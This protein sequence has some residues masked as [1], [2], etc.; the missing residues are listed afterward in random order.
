MFILDNILLYPKFYCYYCRTLKYIA[1]FE[2]SAQIKLGL[3]S[4][5]VSLHFR[6]CVVDNCQEHIE[7]DEEYKEN[8]SE[9]F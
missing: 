9:P 7:Q 1:F 3:L 6:V 5:Q 8:I 4:W 2:E